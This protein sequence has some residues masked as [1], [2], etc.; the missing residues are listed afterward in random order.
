MTDR[1]PPMMKCGHAANASSE[2]QPVC[3]ICWGKPEAKEVDE[4]PP[5][6]EGRTAKC[7]YSRRRDGSPCTSEKPSDPSLPFFSHEKDKE[8]DRFYCGC[9]GWD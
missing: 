1:E 7:S 2:G 8:H 3:A 9:W 4:S 5:S 6:L